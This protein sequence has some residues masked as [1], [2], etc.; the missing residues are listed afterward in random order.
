MAAIDAVSRDELV[1]FIE[2][3]VPGTWT[4]LVMR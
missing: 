2:R 1:R 4:T 3:Y